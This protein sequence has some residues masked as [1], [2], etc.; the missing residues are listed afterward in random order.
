MTTLRKIEK[1]QAE[2]NRKFDVAKQILELLKTLDE[3]EA[4]EVLEMLQESE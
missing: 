3:D 1:K 4:D 2:T